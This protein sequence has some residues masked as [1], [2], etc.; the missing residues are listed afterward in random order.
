MDMRDIVPR[1]EFP[2]QNFP[3]AV[4]ERRKNPRFAMHC[5]D[6]PAYLGRLRAV[7]SQRDRQCQR[8]RRLLRKR[9]SSCLGDK[10]VEYVLTF[11]PEL[12][13]AAAPWG[14]RF[15]GNVVRVEPNAAPG[16]P[17][18]VAVHTTKRRYLSSD[19]S[20]GF[21]HPSAARTPI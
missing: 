15:Y 12:T 11:P 2:H 5:L 3:A 16:G 19:E 14:V 17:Y 8:R 13:H 1:W 9:V 10:S 21:N 4:S 18:G 6:L 20:D 7:D